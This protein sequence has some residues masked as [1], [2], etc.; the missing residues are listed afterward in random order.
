MSPISSCISAILILP[1][2]HPAPLT[3]QSSNFHSN[4]TMCNS[5]SHISAAVGS[6]PA[7]RQLSVWN[8]ATLQL[9]TFLSLSLQ[10]HNFPSVAQHSHPAPISV[11][12]SLPLSLCHPP[13]NVLKTNDCYSATQQLRAPRT[14]VTRR[15]SVA[16]LLVLLLTSRH[17]RS[18]AAFWP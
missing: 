4:S 12:S 13:A 10:L 3:L 8:P 17:I 2:C 14:I 11:P 9:P 5:A 6:H 7:S 18:S 1:P 16:L 15:K